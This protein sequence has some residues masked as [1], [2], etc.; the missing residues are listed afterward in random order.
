MLVEL[1]KFI[2]QLKHGDLVFF[3]FS[4]HGAGSTGDN[5]FLVPSDFG[6]QTLATKA[7]SLKDVKQQLNQAVDRLQILILLDCCRFNRQDE[8]FKMVVSSHDLASIHPLMD[9]VKASLS[10]DVPVLMKSEAAVGQNVT[11][12]TPYIATQKLRLLRCN[13]VQMKSYFVKSAWHCISLLGIVASS[14]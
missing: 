7:L 13:S 9:S 1:K 3:Y 12:R 4:G 8:T 10:A 2:A 11:L 6:A 5:V 14:G